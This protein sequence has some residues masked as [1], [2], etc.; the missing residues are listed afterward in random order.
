MNHTIHPRDRWIPWYFVAFFLV[1]ALVDG[2]MVTLAVRT[3]TGT[4]TDHPYERGLAYNQVVAAAQKQEALGWK[5]TIAYAGNAL[6]FTLRDAAGTTL[7]PERAMAYISRPTQ[8]GMDFTLPLTGER[9]AVTFPQPGLWEVRV[10]AL[11]QGKSYQQSVRLVV[12]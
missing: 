6:H 5:A 1:V 9:T 4:V 3:H 12:E 8:A 2:I 7:K 11:Y 10:E